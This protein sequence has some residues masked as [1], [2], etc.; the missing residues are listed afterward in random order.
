MKLQIT[1]T[2][3]EGKLLTERA[4]L[5]G[6]DVTKYAKFMLARKAMESLNVPTYQMSPRM[7]S[8]V[9]DAIRDDEEG[10]TKPWKF[11]K[12]AD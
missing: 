6:Y 10:K 5:L 12:Y 9:D 4:K 1:L 2:E 8:L 3:E 7:A 11:G